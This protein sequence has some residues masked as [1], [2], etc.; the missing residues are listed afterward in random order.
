MQVEKFNTNLGFNRNC[1]HSI[2]HEKRCS[3][4][5]RSPTNEGI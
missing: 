1:K 5:L 2:I 4:R 3:L